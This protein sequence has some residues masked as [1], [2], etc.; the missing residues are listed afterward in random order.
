MDDY[1]FM[2]FEVGFLRG[3]GSETRATDNRLQTTDNRSRPRSSEIFRGC[4]PWSVSRDFREK[5][6]GWRRRR[7]WEVAH[8]RRGGTENARAWSDGRVA[9]KK[10]AG[11][12]ELVQAFLNKFGDTK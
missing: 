8:D 11:N 1:R 12:P 9:G 10:N 3:G 6:V 4:R 2:S 5:P 7:L